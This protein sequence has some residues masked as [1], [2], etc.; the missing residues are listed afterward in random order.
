MQKSYRKMIHFYILQLCKQ[1]VLLFQ[2]W[3]SKIHTDTEY[4]QIPFVLQSRLLD[5]KCLVDKGF[6]FPRYNNGQLGTHQDKFGLSFDSHLLWYNLYTHFALHQADT[7]LC[8][9][10][11][12]PRICS[13]LVVGKA[14]WD[15]S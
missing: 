7:E 8:Y 12:A 15:I 6:Y 11:V 2:D 3:D 1:G 4:S 14:P 9:T 10:K 5:G 13:S